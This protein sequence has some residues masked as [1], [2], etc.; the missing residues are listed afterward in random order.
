MHRRLFHRCALWLLPLLVARAFVPVGFMLSASEHGLRLEFC[1]AQSSALVH[2]LASLPGHVSN[3]TG[4]A[5]AHSDATAD[6]THKGHQHDE[7]AALQAACPFGLATAA[8]TFD[9]PALRSVGPGPSD[10]RSELDVSMSASAGPLRADRIR[11]PP[12]YS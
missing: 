11:G 1:P 5:I 10:E 4:H 9:V 3:H 7:A 2:A 12:T 6:Q 8:I